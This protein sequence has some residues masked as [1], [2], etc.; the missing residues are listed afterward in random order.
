MNIRVLHI[1][2]GSINDGASKGAIYL[3]KYLLK[4]G[5]NSKI[6]FGSIDGQQEKNIDNIYY[7]K[8]NY[9][10]KFIYYFYK[11]IFKMIFNLFFSKKFIF[12]TGFYGVNIKKNKFFKEADIIHLHSV[13]DF[14]SLNTIKS[15]KKPIV[16]SLRDW[17]IMTG[18]YHLPN[19][20]NSYQNK[21]NMEN[22]ISMFLFKIKKKFVTNQN[23][24]NYTAISDR[25]KKDFQLTYNNT[26]INR[27]YNLTDQESFYT[28]NSDNLKTSLNINTSKKIILF[29]A[30]RISDPSKGS[31]YLDVILSKL[32]PKLYFIITFGVNDKINLSKYDFEYVNFGEIN[33]NNLLRKIYS[34]SNLFLC[35]S[36]Q[37]SFGKTVLESLLCS[38]PVV[39]FDIGAVNEII[40]HRKNG[41]LAK[42]FDIDD[43]ILGINFLLKVEKE[44]RSSEMIEKKLKYLQPFFHDEITKLH[45]DQYNQII[46]I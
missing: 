10:E 26:K 43:F 9:Y 16:W 2:S 4:R 46:N 27:I 14:V 40:V 11:V 15:I 25:I 42:P 28:T 19:F 3:H 29:G 36:I 38:T 44:W 1:V 5:V 34:I 31:K 24:I 30:Q 23:N 35:T 7:F 8:K 41:Y 33:D 32:D 6:L 13:N 21:F 12:T 22:Y 17:W 18:G 39:A 20:D 37:E 45:L